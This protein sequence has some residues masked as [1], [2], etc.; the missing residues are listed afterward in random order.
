VSTT[1]SGIDRE[2]DREVDKEVAVGDSEN[3]TE[4]SAVVP[5]EEIEGV[6]PRCASSALRA[7]PVLSEGGWFQVVKCQHC[8]YSVSRE[9]WH[10]LG[11]VQLTSAGLVLD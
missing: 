9:P 5:R 8:L 2:V 11:P 4:E 10:L 3:G 6:C 1:E 7:Y